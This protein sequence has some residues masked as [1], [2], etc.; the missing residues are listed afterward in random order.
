M[1]LPVARRAVFSL[2]L[3][4]HALSLSRCQIVQKQKRKEKKNV[5]GQVRVLV[6]FLHYANNY[7]TFSKLCSFC[8]KWSNYTSNFNFEW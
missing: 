4:L 1:P 5:Y 8:Q 6:Y 3:A 2:A 7:V